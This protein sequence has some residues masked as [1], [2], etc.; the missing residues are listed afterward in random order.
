MCGAISR[1]ALPRGRAHPRSGVFCLGLPRPPL[2]A[3]GVI[4]AGTSDAPVAEEAA[5]PAAMRGCRVHRFD[6]CGVSGIHRLARHL[7]RL[8]RCCAVGVVA[9]FEG[10][11]PSV[12]GGLTYH[13][14]TSTLYQVAVHEIGH[15]LGLFH[16]TDQSAVMNPTAMGVQ[17]QDANAADIAGILALYA[18]APCFA[19]GSAILTAA[20]PV[21]VEHLAVGSL[22]PTQRS[23]SPRTWL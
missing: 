5:L 15:A 19:E 14:Y 23:G 9:G 13:G 20:G 11:L 21:A 3:V 12:I 1:A 18:H 22:I 4:S 16:S 17:N 7:P 8:R 6:D 10:A 2:P